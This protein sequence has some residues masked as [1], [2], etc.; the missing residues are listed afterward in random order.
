[1][2]QSEDAFRQYIYWRKGK[3]EEFYEVLLEKLSEVLR[4]EKKSL[5]TVELYSVWVS[6][7]LKW[8]GKEGGILMIFS[9]LLK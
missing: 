8:S 1:M 9:L 2:T 3:R 7:F 6:K 5:K 4:G